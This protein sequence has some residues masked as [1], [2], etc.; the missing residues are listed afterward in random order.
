SGRPITVIVVD[1]VWRHARRMAVRLSELLPDVRHMQLTPEQLSIYMRKQSQADRICTVEAA[2]LF[3]QLF[4]ESEETTGAMI[5]GVR[6]N[7][8]AL[9]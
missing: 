8:S 1:A 3:L 4:G 2:A 6:I 7:N 5:E 9:K